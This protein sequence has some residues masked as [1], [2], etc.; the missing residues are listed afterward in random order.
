MPVDAN[1]AKAIFMTALEKSAPAERAAYIAES[2]ACDDELRRRVEVLLKAHDDPGSFMKSPD[3]ALAPAV[4]ATIDDPISERPGTV[5]GAYKLLEQIGEGGFGVVFM[6]EQQQPVRRKVALKVL[7]PGMDTRQVVA[8]FE[9]ERQ[10]LALMDH[11]HIAR[12]FDGGE[13]ATGRPYFVMELVRGVPITEFCD[14]NHLSV[15]QR[16]ELFGSVCSAVQHAHQKGVI[17]RDLKP[18][19]VLVSL[20]D[21]KA[22]VKVIDFGIAKAAGQHLTDKTLFTGFAQM[23]GTPLYMSPEQAQM[24]GLDADTRSDIYSLGVLL[25]ELLTGTT[26]FTRERLQQ[27]GYDE[28]RRIIR[29][30]EPPRPS[31]RLSTLGQTAATVSADRQSDPKRLSQL[32][33]GELDWIVMKCLEKDRNRRYETANGFALDVQRYLAD[34]PVLACPPSAAYRLRKFARRNKGPILAAALVLLALVGGIIGTTW[35]L[36]RA[37]RQRLVAEANAE[38][39][40][41]AQER[42]EQGFTKAKKAVEHYLTAVTDDPDLKD[43]HDLHPLRKKLLGAAVPFY[44]WFAEQRPGETAWE[45]ERGRAYYRLAAVRY[46]MG[47]TEAALKDYERVRAIF[48]KLADEFPDNPEYRWQVATSDLSLGHFRQDLGQYQEAERSYRRAIPVLEALAAEYPGVPLYRHELARSQHLLSVRI[49]DDGQMAAAEQA[50]HRALELLEKLVAEC[51]AEPENRRYQAHA[52]DCLGTIRTRQR[53]LPEAE[54]AYRRSLEIST[55][56]AAEFPAQRHYRS[57]AGVTHGNLGLTLRHAGKKRE[58]R[59]AYRSAIEIMEKLAGDFPNVPEYRSHLGRIYAQ[60]ADVLRE[61]G[62]QP[63]ADETHRRA[64]DVYEKLVADFPRIPKDRCLLAGTYVDWG[65][66]VCKRGNAEAS[67]SWFAKAIAL[68]APL[69]RQEPPI[70]GSRLFLRNAYWH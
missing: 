13:T 64:I 50:C 22:V 66:W 58:A 1:A 51:P 8:R 47:E 55:R 65:R 30:E 21:D 15:R 7:K 69:A 54:D 57:M 38:K 12:V 9:A 24:S 36:V 60:L 43:K 56:L 67:L 70:Y 18:S 68:L 31:A 2:C 44:E 32:F 23:V 40:A 63:A 42:A 33:R 11:P 4:G 59:R 48:N 6:A 39:A 19:N 41:R 25:Y 34:E 5:I 52:L 26:P 53:R 61:L 46:A 10:A 62:Q 29:E 3:N 49:R 14:Q 20:H 27:A 35:G 28:I 17:H 37:E 16:L 45:A